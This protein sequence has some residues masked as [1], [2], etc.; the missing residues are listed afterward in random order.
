MR[1]RSLCLKWAGILMANILPSVLISG[2]ERRKRVNLYMSATAQMV[3][4]VAM[5]ESK[6]AAQEILEISDLLL[7][8]L[9]D[10]STRKMQAPLKYH[11]IPE[12]GKE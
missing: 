6:L 4:F 7:L 9:M 2:L 8:I 10:I 11:Q 1:A 3:C 12:H 5:E